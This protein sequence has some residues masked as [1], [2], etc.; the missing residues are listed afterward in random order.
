MPDTIT[1]IG[2]RAFEYCSALN[3]INSDEIGTFNLP[4]SITNFDTEAFYGV[5]VVNLIIPDSVITIGQHAF[6][7]NNKLETVAFGKNVKT[8][9]VY[10]FYQDS[11][12][13]VTVPNTVTSINS[14]AFTGV[15]HVYYNGSVS[16][17][18]WG[19]STLN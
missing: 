8:I 19:A 18:P 10:A 1:N 12:L 5:S 2:T 7:V 9:G 6:S 4:N 3:T 14:T 17:A 15:K 16:G 13:I 11:N